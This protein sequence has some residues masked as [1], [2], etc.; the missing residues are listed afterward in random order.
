MDAGRL[1]LV[2]TYARG[3]GI[4][5]AIR[6]NVGV[7]VLRYDADSG[8]DGNLGRWKFKQ[9]YAMLCSLQ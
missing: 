3:Y 2:W 4:I 9:G 5:R 1:S 7:P 8:R 6:V